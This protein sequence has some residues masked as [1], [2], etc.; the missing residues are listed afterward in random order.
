MFLNRFVV[1]KRT[2]V[3][4]M[5]FQEGGNILLGAGVLGDGLGALT[6]GVL[7]KFTWKQQTDGG[8][9]FSTGNG[10]TFVIMRQTRCLCSNTFEDVVHETVHDAHRLTG[11]PCVRMNLFQHLVDVDGV[12]LLPPAFLFLIGFGY[13]LLCLSGFLGSFT[14]RLGWHL[15]INRSRTD[16]HTSS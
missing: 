1:L 11:Y 15:L 13:I 2:V 14:A 5:F 12:T 9:N 3:L 16:R 4:Y 7:G 10:G 8:L 6:D